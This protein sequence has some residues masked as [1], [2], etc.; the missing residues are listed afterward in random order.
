M[1]SERRIDLQTI[2]TELAVWRMSDYD[3]AGRASFWLS[4][5]RR[6]SAVLVNLAKYKTASAMCD[7]SI[8]KGK[9]VVRYL[10]V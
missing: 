10:K 5:L 1:Q 3:Q 9:F 8:G 6:G 2:L 7:G 4:R